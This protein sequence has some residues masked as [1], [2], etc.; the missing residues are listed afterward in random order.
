[1]YE[2]VDIQAHVFTQMRWSLLG[3][4]LILFSLRGRISAFSLAFFLMQK[5]ALFTL[6]ISHLN[7]EVLCAATQKCFAAISIPQLYKIY[8]TKSLWKD[9]DLSQGR[10]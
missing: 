5:L 1:M 9:E 4:F 3:F 6:L 8:S 10:I 2:I 7:Q